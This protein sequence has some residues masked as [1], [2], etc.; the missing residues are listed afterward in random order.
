ELAEKIKTL[1]AAN[2]IEAT[3]QRARQ[4]QS[5]AEEPITA[6]IR[7]RAE[8]TPNADRSMPS[9]SAAASTLQ[10]SEAQD[11]S[12]KSAMTFQERLAAE[13]LGAESQER[14]L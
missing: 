4:K 1:K 7:R 12:V 11:S 14:T 13:R 6:R 2:T 5:T 8:A 10:D 9:H 3:P